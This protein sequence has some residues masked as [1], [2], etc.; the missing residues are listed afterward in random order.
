MSDKYQFDATFIRDTEKAIL[1]DVEDV[2]EVWFPKSMVSWIHKGIY[3]CSTSFAK[4]KG[5]LE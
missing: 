3:E 2:G 4:Q 1:L 5:L